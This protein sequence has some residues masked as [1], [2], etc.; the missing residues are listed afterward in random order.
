MSIERLEYKITGDSSSFRNSIKKSEKSVSGFQQQLKGVG[1]ALKI[2]FTA[3]LVGA[4]Y[5]SVRLAKDFSKSMTKIKSLV[6]VAG[7]EVD[8]MG[9][10]ARKMAIE[11]GISANEAAEALFFITSAGL[12]GSNAMDVLEASLKAASVGLGET[13]TVADLATSALNAYGVENL[14]ASEATDVLVSAVREGKLEASE[15]GQSM[16]RVLPIASQLGVEFHDVGGAFAAM[17]RT[18]T[19]AAEASTA[20]KGIFLGLVKPTAEGRK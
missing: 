1:S 17:S 10:K 12:R 8:A 14:S 15:L 5:Q 11:T 4:G 7:D 16:G 2:A 13:K 9:V 6:G 18:G 3:A 19:N 20:L